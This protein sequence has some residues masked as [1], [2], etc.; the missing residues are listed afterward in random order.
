LNQEGVVV[1]N[2]G[3]INL[4]GSRPAP[5]RRPL[6]SEA[7]SLILSRTQDTV[8]TGAVHHHARTPG[9][10]VY[11]LGEV[12]NPGF[13]RVP[14]GGMDVMSAIA[15]ANG[16]SDDASREGTL[17]VRLTPDGYQVQEVNLESFGTPDFAQTATVSLQSY[18][19]VY[20]PRSRVG[21]FSYFAKNV[22]AG[23]A[24]F[25]RIAYD[26]RYITTGEV[27]GSDGYA[28]IRPAVQ[29]PRPLR[30]KGS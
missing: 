30:Q 18:D 15:M 20:V 14:T 12:E 8:G 28:G 17:V 29:R 9:R 24:N 1:L 2:G 25:T 21:D 4:M 13:Y 6:L 27:G 22:L 19:I 11:N 7:D 5:H 23:L 3:S 26:V 16:F 10:R